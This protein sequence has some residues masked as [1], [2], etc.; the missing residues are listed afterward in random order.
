MRFR[1][2][3]P[4]TRRSRNAE[5]ISAAWLGTT[6]RYRLLNQHELKS[7]HGASAITAMLL[8]Q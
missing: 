7:F 4:A 8:M 3:M 5:V 1:S 2:T 6:R